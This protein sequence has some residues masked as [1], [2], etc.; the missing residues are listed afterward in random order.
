MAKHKAPWHA[1]L[2]NGMGP[3]AFTLDELRAAKHAHGFATEPIEGPEGIAYVLGAFRSLLLFGMACVGDDTYP[4]LTRCWR[5]LNRLFKDDPAF[6]GDVFIQ[7]WILMDF[8][9]GPNGET[10]LD[11]FE[12][13]LKET[14]AG[15]IGEPFIDAARKSRLGLH[16]NVM[17]SKQVGRFRELFTGAVTSTFPTVEEYGSGEILLSRMVAYDDQVFVFGDARGFPKE[18]KRQVEDMVTNELVYFDAPSPIAQYEKFMKLAGP[19]WM[20]RITNNE[21]VPA[22]GPDH[23]LSY[24][25][26]DG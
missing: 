1:V 21:D 25:D 16:Q 6:R 7:S 11:Y 4:P 10:A 18:A 14:D 23:Y 26:D 24:L 17:R 13:F 8:P 5:D 2:P 9:F 22:L 20:S 12:V 19:F 15:T 3:A